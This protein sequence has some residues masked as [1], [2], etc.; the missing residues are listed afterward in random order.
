[1]ASLQGQADT[2]AEVAAITKQLVAVR[3]SLL[4]DLVWL[5]RY[6]DPYLQVM[7]SSGAITGGDVCCSR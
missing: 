3:S 2:E 4:D 1:M 6:S 5:A 7:S